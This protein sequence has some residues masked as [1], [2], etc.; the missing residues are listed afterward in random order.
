MWTGIAIYVFFTLVNNVNTFVDFTVDNEP[1]GSFT[2]NANTE[3][4]TLYQVPVFSHTGLQDG[5]HSLLVSAAASS[6]FSYVNFDY[7]IYT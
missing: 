7:A 1:A 6:V 5:H 3:T 4:S 2:H